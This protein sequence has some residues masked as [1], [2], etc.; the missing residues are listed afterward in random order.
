MQS[1][2]ASHFQFGQPQELTYV[3]LVLSH[4]HQQ[5]LGNKLA[6]KYGMLQCSVLVS[7]SDGC[8]TR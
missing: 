6:T 3:L 2:G 7:H 1:A 8:I 5:P 4:A